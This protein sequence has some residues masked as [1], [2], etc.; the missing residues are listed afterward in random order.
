MDCRLWGDTLLIPDQMQSLNSILVLVFI[1]IF[2]A[3]FYPLAGKFIKV[4]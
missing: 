2:S 1:P 3:V 4:T